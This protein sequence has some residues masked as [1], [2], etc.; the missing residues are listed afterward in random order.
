M[1]QW[2]KQRGV[3]VISYRGSLVE[4]D[5]VKGKEGVQGEEE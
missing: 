2:S 3:T 1:D 4:M 5:E